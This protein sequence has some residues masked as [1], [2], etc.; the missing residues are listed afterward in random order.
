MFDKTT[1]QQLINTLEFETKQNLILTALIDAKLIDR[2]EVK[3]KVE[4]ALSEFY[5]YISELEKKYNEKLNEERL[6]QKRK[7]EEAIKKLQNAVLVNIPDD[8]IGKA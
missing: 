7:Q 2:E 5:I 1:L 4:T 8:K 3:K 6:E